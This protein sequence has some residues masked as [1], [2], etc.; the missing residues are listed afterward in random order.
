ML[1]DAPIHSYD[2]PKQS[3]VLRTKEEAWEGP[4]MNNYPCGTFRFESQYHSQMTVS[5]GGRP[6]AMTRT[7]HRVSSHP[8]GLVWKIQG[9]Q[10]PGDVVVM[11]RS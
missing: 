6:I 9:N 2:L 8:V 10:K 4:I 5:R 3:L 11:S 7:F 1:G